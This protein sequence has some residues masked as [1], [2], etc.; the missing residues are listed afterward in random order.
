MCVSIDL[1]RQLLNAYDT[2]PDSLKDLPVE[3]PIRD[4]ARELAAAMNSATPKKRQSGSHQTDKDS[5]AAATPSTP[6][7]A[8]RQSG[9]HQ[10]DTA[11]KEAAPATPSSTPSKPHRLSGSHTHHKDKKR[12][13]DR[14]PSPLVTPD[15]PPRP[16]DAALGLVKSDSASG[17]KSRSAG[18][19]S[20]TRSLTDLRMVQERLVLAMQRTQWKLACLH[21]LLRD[22]EITPGNAAQI[23]AQFPPQQAPLKSFLN[24]ISLFAMLK[25]E[26]TETL[27]LGD[28]GQSQLRL[29]EATRT[30]KIVNAV[31]SLHCGAVQCL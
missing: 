27:S 3:K 18:P 16:M 23:L 19:P 28:L 22:G 12:E 5:A 25:K 21:R 17:M 30:T 11:D 9:S 20:L 4:P 31:R 13:D 14:K 8:H 7:K 29:V 2:S 24:A 1:W 6:S 15:E 10:R 26:V